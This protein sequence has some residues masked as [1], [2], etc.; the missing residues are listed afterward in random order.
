MRDG[1]R[2]I[3][4]D[5]H[6]IEPIGL[7]RH[8]LAPEFRDQA[9]CYAD[10]QPG[11]DGPPEMCVNGAPVM[12]LSASARK[13]V[14]DAAYPRREVLMSS[15]APQGHLDSMDRCGID[16]A[17][18]FP[19]YGSYLVSIDTMAADLAHAFARAYNDWLRDFCSAAP[20]R[21]VG[22]GLIARHDPAQMV[23]EAR[24]VAGFGWRTLV[25]RPNPVQ[26]RTL[27]D[28]A[29]TS[30]WQLCEDLDL[31]VAV[32]EGTH[33]LLPSAS[34]DR[35]ESRFGMH[36]CSHPMEQMM[37]SLSLLEGG[38]LA[39]HPRLRVAFLEA[40]CSWLPYWLWRLDEV[41]YKYLQDEVAGRLAMKPSAYFRR[42]CLV[43]IEPGEP[44]LAQVVPWIGAD[45]IVFGTDFP[46]LDH[47]EGIVDELLAAWRELPTGTVRKLLC[48]NA[49]R[50]YRLG[51]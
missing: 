26:G 37:A 19:T 10:L 46:H 25:I 3:D 4:G 1:F 17:V 16:A 18:L 39:R 20:G 2:I 5:R 32:H 35:F 14:A 42:Q 33:A 31:A 47:D 7:W 48:D 29:Y 23:A 21:L 51:G 24:R 49:V 8:Y 34:A 50:F 38:V 13:A 45:N 43:G 40:G 11:A 22:A 36:A 30:F 15:Q 12:R 41:E 9:P 28:A 27:G 44:M 6:V